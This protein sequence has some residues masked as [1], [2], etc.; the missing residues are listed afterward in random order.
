MTSQTATFI[1]NHGYC[2]TFINLFW[3]YCVFPRLFGFS[4]PRHNFSDSHILLSEKFT[5]LLDDNHHTSTCESSTV[6][7]F[8]SDKSPG[9]FWNENTWHNKPLVVLKKNIRFEN[10]YWKQSPVSFNHCWLT[11]VVEATK[12]NWLQ[13][14]Q[15][16]FNPQVLSTEEVVPDLPN[17]LWA[18]T[19]PKP[20]QQKGKR[21][22]LSGYHHLTVGERVVKG[23]LIFKS[24]WFWYM[25][26]VGN[27]WETRY[28]YKHRHCH[29]HIST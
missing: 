3:N 10:N 29:C 27:T 9:P 4:R 12:K 17:W 24:N 6:V 18:R 14:F 1:H 5:G 21:S 28:I 8:L 23:K 16:Y 25:K 15:Q 20:S 22:A 2:S 19:L 26:Y 13:Q 7:G 11:T